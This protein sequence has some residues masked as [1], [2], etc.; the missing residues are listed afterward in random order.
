MRGQRVAPFFSFAI[1]AWI[2]YALTW[3]AETGASRGAEGPRGFASY[4]EAQRRSRF[5]TLD[6]E[7]L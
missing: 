7:K 2:P 6:S 1:A 4:L 5:L 3:D